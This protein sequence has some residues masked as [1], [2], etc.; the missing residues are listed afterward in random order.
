VGVYTLRLN[1]ECSEKFNRILIKIIILTLF[2]LFISQGIIYYQPLNYQLSLIDKLEGEL[3]NYE[4]VYPAGDV[5]LNVTHLTLRVINPYLTSLPEA[6][7]Y[8]NDKQVGDFTNLQYTLIVEKGDRI[9]VDASSYFMDLLIEITPSEDLKIK[10]DIIR[11]N[12][13]EQAII[14]VEH[15]D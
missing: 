15:H 3:I 11:V 13:G 14:Q 1:S 9:I 6:K 5:L 4:N 8:L 2:F 7:I 10:K 12:S